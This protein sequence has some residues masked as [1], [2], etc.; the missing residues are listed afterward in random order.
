[1]LNLIPNQNHVIY[2]SGYKREEDSEK[3]KF[4]LVPSSAL[5]RV[6]KRFE[7]GAKKYGHFNWRKADLSDLEQLNRFNDAMYR[8]LIQ[9]LDG[10][11]DEDH[12]SAMICNA[13][14]IID[15]QEKVV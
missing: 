11:T 6:A 14:M 10:E 9:Y 3:L 1:M 8:H 4:S 2:D 15:L 13:M 7:E 12:L 5:K